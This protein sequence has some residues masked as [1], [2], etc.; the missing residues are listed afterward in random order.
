MS[1]THQIVSISRKV[2]NQ[3][4]IG[5]F[6]EYSI[7]NSFILQYNLLLINRIRSI[8]YD[9][10]HKHYKGLPILCT[11]SDLEQLIKDIECIEDT[12]ELHKSPKFYQTF[13]VL[14]YND[15]P[16]YTRR[17]LS[18][19]KLNLIRFMNQSSYDYYIIQ[20]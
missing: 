4:S 1:D 6:P 12:E 18:V 9:R 17:N 11:K 5:E 2:Y 7:S 3:L 8:V 13:G 15:P 20:D 16:D 14:S 10:S 19:I